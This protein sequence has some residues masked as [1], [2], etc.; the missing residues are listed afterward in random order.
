MTCTAA[1]GSWWRGSGGAGGGR[2]VAVAQAGLQMHQAE[3]VTH[4]LTTCSTAV[5][6]A[7]CCSQHEEP[8]MPNGQHRS[9]RGVRCQ[10]R[11]PNWNS[12]FMLPLRIYGPF[13]AAR[14]P[15]CLS[16]CSFPMGFVSDR[17]YAGIARRQ[18]TD[19]R[20]PDCLWGVSK[21]VHTPLTAAWTAHNS[22]GTLEGSVGS[23]CCG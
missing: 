8:C 19:P 2:L 16:A 23:M 21:V 1:A 4:I 6:L 22:P 9:R 15:A 5:C 18:F 20:Q 12:A 10:G 7:A 13:P 17:L 3:C 11:Y 14:P